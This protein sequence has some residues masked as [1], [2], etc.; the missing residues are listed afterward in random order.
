MVIDK[1][2]RST[3]NNNNSLI[4]PLLGH[5]TKET[6]IALK[7]SYEKLRALNHRFKKWKQSPKQKGLNLSN[8]NESIN[9]KEYMEQVNLTLMEIDELISENFNYEL[10][11]E[12]GFDPNEKNNIYKGIDSEF[13]QFVNNMKNLKKDKNINY[14]FDINSYF[15]KCQNEINAI[16]KKLR[17]DKFVK[18][19]IFGQEHSSQS[20]ININPNI[21]RGQIKLYSR[22]REYNNSTII[23]KNNIQFSVEEESLSNLIQLILFCFGICFLLFVCYLC[24]P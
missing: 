9:I 24:M 4:I 10:D 13:E 1:W 8:E 6:F 23:E 22:K 2:T 11:G 7:K 16:N 3:S 19:I 15:S 17:K 14:N 12:K 18:N 20:L 5:K 21:D